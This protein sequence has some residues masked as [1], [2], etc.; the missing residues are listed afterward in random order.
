MS[1][2]DAD[3][4]VRLRRLLEM[5]SDEKKFEVALELKKQGRRV[6][7]VFN[8]YIPEELLLA[9]GILPWRI[10]GSHKANIAKATILR[11]PN[12]N[13]VVTHI[14]QSAMDGELDFLDGV[15]FTHLDDDQRRL[16]DCWLHMGKTP[17]FTHYLYIPRRTVPICIEAFRSGMARLVAKLEMWIGDIISE[18]SLHHAIEIYNKW[19]ACLR[20]LYELRKKDFPPLSGSEFLALTTASFTMPKDA[21]TQELESLF[22]YLKE[23]KAAVKKIRPR[24]LVSSEDLDLPD[25]LKLVEDQGCLVSMDDLNTGSRYIWHEVDA[26]TDLLYALAKR[27]LT[28]PPCP[29]MFDWDGYIDHLIQLVRDFDIDGVLNLPLMW[30]MWRDDITPYLQQRLRE[31]GIP[32]MTFYCEYHLADVG[33][34]QT[35]IGGFLESLERKDR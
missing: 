26:G 25:Y 2:I 23:R 4:E 11:P 32:V 33:R 17:E 7:G 13:L 16:W 8:D 14:I 28:R 15:V 3:A 10:T 18:E 20:R 5:G 24:L 34:L 21:F 22:N 1:Q 27:Y 19:R 35:Q 29:R 31:A 12:V 9:A 6:V 30:S